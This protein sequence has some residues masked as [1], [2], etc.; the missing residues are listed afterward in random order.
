MKVV[1]FFFAKPLAIGSL[2]EALNYN[3]N[4][5][6]II[7]QWLGL[8]ALNQD[9]LAEGI[10][11]KPMK[12][13]QLET[14]KG[15]I[16][17]IIKRK[18]E[19]F[20]EIKFHQVQK[21]SYIPSDSSLEDQLDFLLPDLQS[22]VNANRLQNTFSKIGQIDPDNK[23]RMEAI[24][25]LF[26]EDVFDSFEEEQGDILNMIPNEQVMWLKSRIALDIDLCIQQYLATQGFSY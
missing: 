17:P 24:K 6:S 1:T 8:P 12:S 13:I 20:N 10:V 9:N 2:T 4:F 7:S 25:Q 18:H 21:W 16:R 15:S 3:L 19:R 14:K 23:T 22:L 26:L 11:I 5:Q